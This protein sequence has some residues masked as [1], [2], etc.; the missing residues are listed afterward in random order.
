MIRH[1]DEVVEFDIETVG[2]SLDLAATTSSVTTESY[3]IGLNL[4][5]NAAPIRVQTVTK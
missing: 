2:E 1:H 5:E 3:S 4:T